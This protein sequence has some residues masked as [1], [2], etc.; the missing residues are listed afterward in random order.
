M[1]KI[2]NSIPNTI[3]SL[4]LFCGCLAIVY[5]LNNDLIMAFYL[6]L[7][8]AILDF[9][10]GFAARMLNAYSPIGKELDSLADVVSFG[11]VPA[12][13]MYMSGMGAFAFVIAI[14]SALR[15]AK[16]NIDTRQQTTFIGLP[17]PANALFFCSI[18]F[19]VQ[20]YPDSSVVDI[21]FT[22]EYFQYITAVVFSLLLVSEIPMFS[23]KFK[24]YS[25][26]KNAKV[27]I[28]LLLSIC[29]LIAFKFFAVP[30]IIVTYV[31]FSVLEYIINKKK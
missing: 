28:F 29:G 25:F 20:S 19:L 10:D 12:M 2:I 26:A 16:F 7:G 24:S 22:N 13:I 27:Y 17:T 30:F 31:L 21:I 14:F 1:R 23:L 3:T 11:V 15:L 8:S 4:N 5:A 18:G 9:F 6:M